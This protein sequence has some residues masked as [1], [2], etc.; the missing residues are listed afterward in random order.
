MSHP[1]EIAPEAPCVEQLLR[2]PKSRL[3]LLQEWAIDGTGVAASARVR[4]SDGRI[5][6]VK[7]SWTDGW[8]LP[9]GAVEPNEIPAEAARR[10]VREETGLD[11]TIGSPLVVLD[12]RYLSENGDK[13]WFSA[14]YVVYAAAAEGEIPDVSQLGVTDDEIL[15]ARWFDTLPEEFHDGELLRPYL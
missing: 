6:L 1:H 2:L 3:E 9:G 8:F 15:A 12:Q 11:A 10:E 14:L 5:A 7:T 13:E 4:D